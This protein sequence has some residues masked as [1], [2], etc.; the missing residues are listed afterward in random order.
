MADEH[1]LPVGSPIV[2]GGKSQHAGKHGVIDHYTPQKVSVRLEDGSS[3]RCM[4]SRP[5]GR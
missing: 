1:S 4:K 5:M 3:P 2:V